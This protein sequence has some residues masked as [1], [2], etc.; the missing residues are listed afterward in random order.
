MVAFKIKEQ[1]KDKKN[2]HIG[3]F[4]G[5]E[6]LASISTIMEGLNAAYNITDDEKLKENIKQALNLGTKYLSKYQV[7]YGN[8]AGGLFTDISCRKTKNPRDCEIRIDNVQHALSSWILYKENK[9]HW[10]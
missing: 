2:P 3:S 1:I 9:K 8:L 10:K 4:I 5:D 6:K 7:K